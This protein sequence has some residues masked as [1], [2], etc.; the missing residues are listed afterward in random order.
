MYKK[1][2]TIILIGIMASSIMLTGC[3][4]TASTGNSVGGAPMSGNGAS[5]GGQIAAANKLV[6]KVTDI[7]GNELTMQV[8]VLSENFPGAGAGTGGEGA[9][10]ER[11]ERPEGGEG[12]NERPE[13]G[14]PVEDGSRRAG[15]ETPA[16]DGSRRAG[17]GA[18][19]GGEAVD[20]SEMVE[21]TEEIKIINVPVGTKVMQFANE[22]TFS[23]IQ[24]DMYITVDLG[25]NEEISAINI[26]G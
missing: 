4:D 14:P 16:E 6:G 1:A 7:L 8:G 3:S 11:P 22:M 21:L 12:G 18:G 10:G 23:Q 19:E 17:G 5:Q 15:G 26:L 13:S 9:E 2:M 25:E 20:F 24:K